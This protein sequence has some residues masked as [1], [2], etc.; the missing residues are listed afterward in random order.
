DGAAAAHAA[1]AAETV[2]AEIGD[3]ALSARVAAVSAAVALH[4][5]D[6]PMA[7]RLARAAIEAAAATA[8]PAVEGEAH[9]TLGHVLRTT[10]GMAAGLPSYRRAGEVAAAAGLAELHLRAEQ[11]Q[12]L[13][14]PSS[15]H[16]NPLL[17]VRQL[18]MRYGALVTVAVIDLYLADLALAAF[19]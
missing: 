11:E 6:L 17:E 12:A 5:A 7:E 18:G 14:V 4:Q 9:P 3:P 16:G 10:E 2:A 1:G 15:E 13:I 8:Q 19:D